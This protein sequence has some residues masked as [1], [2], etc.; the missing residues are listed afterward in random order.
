[1]ASPRTFPGDPEQRQALAEELHARP[2]VPVIAPAV[3]SCL[4]LFEVDPVVV[5]ERVEELTRLYAVSLPERGADHVI[6]DLPD[7]RLKWERHGEFTSLVFVRFLPGAT[8]ESL[9]TFPSAFDGIPEPWLAQLPGRVIAASDIAVVASKKRL[10]DDD[11]RAATRWFVTSAL[12]ASRVLDGVAWVFTDFKLKEKGRSRVLVVDNGLG[13]AQTARIVQRMVEIEMYR[14]MGLLAYP[15]ARALVSDLNRIEKELAATT[16]SMA[17]PDEPEVEVRALDHL[18]KLAAQVERSI[19]ASMF[20]FSAGQAYYAIVRARV[21]ELREERVR[22]M[23]TLQGFLAR[24]MTPAMDTVEAAA[25]RQEALS[26]RISRA[27][28]LLRTRVDLVREEQNQ[29]LLAAM[30]QRGKLQLRL[31]QAVERLSVAA[32]TYYVV[33]LVAYALKPLHLSW[34]TPEQGAALSIPFAA[35]AVWRVLQRSHHTG[36]S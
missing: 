32:I 13:E 22:D 6:I 4:A 10:R 25:R 18:T 23:R 15:I 5:Y 3:V 30:D 17:G 29:A 16:E 2:A 35:Y 34:L 9:D 14:M 28:A 12:A 33:A 11:L 31:Q 7:G 20:R 27:S 19:A 24:R 21:A 1:M 36:D 26:T 8:L